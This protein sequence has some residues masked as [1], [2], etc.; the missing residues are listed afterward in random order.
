M[1]LVLWLE[2]EMRRV[3]L[4]AF[5]GTDN[6]LKAP[7][8]SYKGYEAFT[9]KHTNY[10]TTKKRY[11]RSTNSNETFKANDNTFRAPGNYC[12]AAD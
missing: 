9:Q 1:A 7:R 6:Y 11:S 2:I 8:L 12:K 3:N 10:M 4:H 5:K